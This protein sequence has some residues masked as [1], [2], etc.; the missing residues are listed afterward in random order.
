MRKPNIS[1]NTFISGTARLN[2]AKTSVMTNETAMTGAE[3]CSA[4]MKTPLVCATMFSNSA[5][6]R[7]APPI[8]NTV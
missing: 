8:G 1:V 7:C 4:T 5:L 2:T 3:I 6:F